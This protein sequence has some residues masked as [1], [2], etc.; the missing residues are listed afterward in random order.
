MYMDFSEHGLFFEK[1]YKSLLRPFRKNEHPEH[2]YEFRFA[3]DSKQI[4]CY[5][6]APINNRIENGISCSMD[7]LTRK[8][9]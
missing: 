3:R 8:V 4:L 2:G 7:S 1:S 6:L 5:P 9:L